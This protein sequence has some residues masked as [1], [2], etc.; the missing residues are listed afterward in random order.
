YTLY[1][2]ITVVMRHC[3]RHIE[4]LLD[5]LNL[6]LD[7][8]P[9]AHVARDGYGG[10][11]ARLDPPHRFLRRGRRDVQ[12]GDAGAPLPEAQGD[13][14]ADPRAAAGHDR[15]LSLDLS[16]SRYARIALSA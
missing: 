15:D 10:C 8:G 14:P 5:R 4:P 9:P 3:G 12:D 16:H 13:R 7:V 1:C 11:A 2:A 6:A